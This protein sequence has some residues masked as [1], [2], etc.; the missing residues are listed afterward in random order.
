VDA[1]E[2]MMLK[3]AVTDH[4]STASVAVTA[5]EKGDKQGARVDSGDGP[6]GD[7]GHAV[8]CI[9]FIGDIAG[10]EGE[11]GDRSGALRLT[12]VG[13]KRT[14]LVPVKADRLV[15]WRSKDVENE[16]LE[17]LGAGEAQFAVHM[18]VTG[19][20]T[21]KE[22]IEESLRNLASKESV[23]AVQSAVKQMT[24]QE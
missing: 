22:R 14:S 10:R 16:R 19:C 15:V 18:W 12:N 5:L 6:G 13:D 8:S 4:Q 3:V 9:Y 24:K 17:V 11:A 20:I 21:N 7:V 1:D 2:L 23:A